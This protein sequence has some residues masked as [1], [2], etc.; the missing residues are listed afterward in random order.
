[1]QIDAEAA[2][3]FDA[4]G[5]IGNAGFA[6]TIES[7]RRKRR[8]DRLLD[9]RAIENI[10]GNFAYFAV[11]ANA[12]RGTFNEEQVA[13]A[14]IDQA[15]EPAVQARGQG[16]VVGS[17]RAGQRTRDFIEVGGIIHGSTK[18]TTAGTRE[19]AAKQGSGLLKDI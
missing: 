4:I 2:E 11:H 14:A 19:F 12:G 9:F 17:F 13:A 15:G 5:R 18:P 6:E 7:V 3:S 8:E 10:G 1:M 16:G